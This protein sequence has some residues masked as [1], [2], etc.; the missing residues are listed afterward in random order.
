[1]PMLL[2]VSEGSSHIEGADML[3]TGARIASI[4]ERVVGSPRR[5]SGTTGDRLQVHKGP[6]LAVNPAKDPFEAQYYY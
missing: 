6:L 1:L 2:S 4:E 5:S 3:P